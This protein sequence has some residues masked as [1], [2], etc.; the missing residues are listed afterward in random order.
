[1]AGTELAT[2][3]VNLTVSARNVAP[4]IKKMFGSADKEAAKAGQSAGKAM[5]EGVAD[6]ID[7]AKGKVESAS[8]KLASARDKEADA[9]GKVRVAEKQLEDVRSRARATAGQIAA[10][11]ER[12]AAAKRKS[13]SATKDAADASKAHEKALK[14]LESASGDSGKTSG[15]SFSGNFKSGL[16]G[17]M[18]GVKALPIAGAFALLGAGAVAA[19]VGALRDG[20]AQEAATD[21]FN[22]RTDTTAAQAQT[23]A[24]AAGEAYVNVFGESVQANLD[25]LEFALKGGII[26]ADATQGE[27]EEAI[28][29]IQT[30]ADAT[31]GTTEEV[32]RSISQMLRTGLVDDYSAAADLIVRASKI[33]LNTSGD[34]FESVTEYS[35]QFRKLGLSGADAIGLMN[36]ALVGGARDA[37]VAAD[38]IKEFAIRV[39][40]GSESSAL[41]FEGLGLSAEDMASRFA[42]GGDVA[43]TAVG[44]LLSRIRQIEDPLKRNEIALALFGTQFE[45]LGGAFDAFNLDTAVASLGDFQGAAGDAANAIGGNSAT[46]VEGAMRAIESAGNDVKGA[47][48]QAF[49][50]YIQQFGEWISTNREA[51]VHFFFELG[52]GVIKAG[53]YLAK[54]GEVGLRVMAGMAEGAGFAAE[55]VLKLASAGAALRGDFVGAKDLW[56]QSNSIGDKFDNAAGKMRGWAD[57]LR[58]DVIPELQ[59]VGATWDT[60][61]EK[62]ESNAAMS[63]AIKRIGAD[64]TITQ[65]E[66]DELKSAIDR[67]SQ[68]MLDNGAS[69]Q[70]VINRRAELVGSFQAA[71]TQAGLNE[72]AV[73]SYSQSLLDVPE[74]VSTEL[75]LRQYIEYFGGENSRQADF[76]NGGSV[77]E[78]TAP[79][80]NRPVG[81]GLGRRSSRP[82]RTGAGLGDA[83][84]YGLTGAQRTF[85]ERFAAEFPEAEITDAGIRTWDDGTGGTGYHYSGQ[86]LDIA[87]PNMGAYA[88]WIAANDPAATELFYD[89]YGG[90]KNGEQIGAIG[91]HGDHV[92]YVPS[93]ASSYDGAA[94]STEGASS[95]MASSGT[96][97]GGSSGGGGGG[98]SEF[99]VFENFIRPQIDDAFSVFGFSGAPRWL[100]IA[101]SGGGGGGGGGGSSS[102][103]SSASTSESSTSGAS[104]TS[105]SGDT[106]SAA[107]AQYGW[108]T[109]SERAA[110][111][112][113]MRRESGGN[114]TAQNPSSTAYGRWQFLDSTWDDVGGTKTSDPALQDQ[115]G[116]AYISQRYGSPSAALAFHDQN[117]WYHDGGWIRGLRGSDVPMVG[118]EGEFVTKASAAS[119]NAEALEFIN[120]GGVIGRGGAVQNNYFQTRG[121]EPQAVAR[122]IASKASLSRMRFNRMVTGAP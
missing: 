87:G 39:V 102:G 93:G 120:A 46:S 33:G 58:D 6:G 25:T 97:S 70:D 110:L 13:T 27:A 85:W 100:D 57:T 113:L 90:I 86:A 42:Q 53:E 119:R 34:L 55:G 28:K 37:D 84:T 69:A 48:A 61:Q 3:Y 1:M 68:S 30:V 121:Y 9:A 24:R 41:A 72:E 66:V 35:T 50:P 52:G 17:I 89:P 116:M 106:L 20:M 82:P 67:E 59:N 11:E 96:S 40:D 31:R 56:D 105:S 115:Y 103:G 112:E 63:D 77:P 74:T 98:G 36:Q 60:M 21:L 81:S 22:A 29:Y 62:A 88:E 16:G 54:F 4:E 83:D 10:A 49:G 79:P 43:R 122:S 80:P 32:A 44:D 109:G 73:R 65:Q 104:S 12:L 47:L 95:D 38:A 5:A 51:V 45:D 108:D 23:F 14:D 76:A 107:A 114:P 2:A 75:E 71:A 101:M 19:F 15:K 111:E 26:S 91:G 92:H 78:D 7:A 18:D 118:Q 94:T 8:K 64:S 99:D 117:N